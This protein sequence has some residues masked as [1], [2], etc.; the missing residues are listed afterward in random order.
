MEREN[1]TLRQELKSSREKV[2][3]AL[4]E[5]SKSREDAQTAQSRLED[6]QHEIHRLRENAGRTDSLKVAEAQ[7]EISLLRQE[8]RTRDSQ[9][10]GQLDQLRGEAE[11]FRGQQEHIELQRRE[12]EELKSRLS[13]A[14]E[15][16]EGALSQAGRREELVKLLESD[17]SHKQQR[18]EQSERLVLGLQG[19]LG[20]KDLA[21]QKW[22]A[23]AESRSRVVADLE[24]QIRK[25]DSHRAE[26]EQ[27]SERIRQAYSELC[28][29][30]G[31]ADIHRQAFSA[32][33]R[34]REILSVES[35]LRQELQEVKQNAELRQY[36]FSNRSAASDQLKSEVARLQDML[37][38]KDGELAALREE[39]LVRTR[40]LRNLTVTHS[41]AEREERARAEQLARLQTAIEQRDHQIAEREKAAHHQASRDQAALL[42]ARNESLRLQTEQART[43]SSLQQRI[44]ELEQQAR[45]ESDYVEACRRIGRLLCVDPTTSPSAHA[46]HVV[47]AVEKITKDLEVNRSRHIHVPPQPYALPYGQGGLTLAPARGADEDW[48]KSQLVESEQRFVKIQV[49]YDSLLRDLAKELRMADIRDAEALLTEVGRLSKSRSAAILPT[50]PRSARPATARVSDPDVKKQLQVALQTIESQD[51]WIAVLN[52]KVDSS[53]FSAQHARELHA[54]RDETARLKAQLADQSSAGDR[55]LLAEYE[56]RIQRHIDFRSALLKTLQMPAVSATDDAILR[57][58]EQVVAEATRPSSS[59]LGALSLAGSNYIGP[60]T[61]WTPSHH[62]LLSSSYS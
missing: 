50:P 17:I 2:A 8:L 5:L 12:V 20:D 19:Q 59:A 14:M 36:E 37:R 46:Q 22:Q 43:V 1:G 15:K 32:G 45:I 9:I 11:R 33:A 55:S 44:S 18:L 13:V 58:T 61:Q 51:K 39:V 3:E 42:D 26:L 21:L 38:A 52:S 62:H 24:T 31:V 30:M 27:R 28:D 23:E 56:A 25:F 6:A 7:A 49:R 40:D 57:R 35:K 4:R 60:A 53:G 34:L 16:G 54:L 41:S 47:A 10:A 29:I 48:L